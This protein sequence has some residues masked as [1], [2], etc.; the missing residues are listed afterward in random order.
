MHRAQQRRSAKLASSPLKNESSAA[1]SDS[2]ID[3]G[4]IPSPGTEQIET[5]ARGALA[6]R[7]IDAEGRGFDDQNQ[8]GLTQIDDPESPR[9]AGVGVGEQRESGFSDARPPA[10]PRPGRLDGAANDACFGDVDAKPVRRTAS[11]IAHLLGSASSGG[12]VDDLRLAM[13]RLE[14]PSARLEERFERSAD[15]EFGLGNFPESSF[16]TPAPARKTAVAPM[17]VGT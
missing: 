4:P 14:I 11:R 16:A 9:R 13:R 17:S 2:G 12:G 6:G 15:A 8:N 5:V 10:A 3:F 7:R 1:T